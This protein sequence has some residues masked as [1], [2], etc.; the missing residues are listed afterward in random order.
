MS[1]FW[2]D[3]MLNKEVVIDRLKLWINDIFVKIISWD[4]CFLGYKYRG[5]YFIV[6]C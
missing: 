1:V 3:G 6:L 2:I 4:I 5:K